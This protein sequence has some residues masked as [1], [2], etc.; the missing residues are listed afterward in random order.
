LNTKK[1]NYPPTETTAIIIFQMQEF[2]SRTV[3]K[4]QKCIRRSD[5]KN[6]EIGMDEVLQFI[7]TWNEN[8]AHPFNWKFTVDDLKKLIG[9]D[10]QI[11]L[12]KSNCSVA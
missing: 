7:N 4:P 11:I 9:I 12:P 6:I 10:E 1:W 3:P 2:K 5:F 8:W